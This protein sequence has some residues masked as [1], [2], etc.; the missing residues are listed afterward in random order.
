MIARLR[1]FAWLAAGFCIAGAGAFVD[2]TRGAGQPQPATAAMV[3][4]APTISVIAARAQEIVDTIL[5][6]GTLVAR[7]EIM[8]G[9]EI[10]GLRITEIVADEGDRVTRGQVLARLTREMLDVHLTQNDALLARAAAA[11][12]Q[13]RSQITQ[14]DAANIEATA[15]LERSRSLAGKGFASQEILDQR[16]AAARSAVARLTAARDGLVFAEAEERQVR[17]Q[18]AEIELRLARTEIRSPVDG[19]VSRR[20]GRIGGLTAMNADALF[21]IVAKGEIELEG[22]MP[23]SRLGALKPGQSVRVEVAGLAPVQGR[24]RLVPAEV[25]RMTRLARVRVALP[26][27]ATLRVGQFA[28]GLVEVERRTTITLP[29]SAVV[30]DQDNATV[31]LVIAGKVAARRVTLGI[32]AGGRVEIRDGVAAGDQ[33]VLRAGAFLRDGDAVSAVPAED[34]RSRP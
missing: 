5:I 14:A 17:A 20:I 9:P 23:E 34:A 16:V 30:F 18:R 6:N 29:L 11:I 15:S 10:D 2:M 33:V 19:I 26:E 24:V 32:T 28:R 21:R 4:P 12:A 25:D 7:E 1:T 27:T 13:A 3:A 31:Q 8:V 22:E